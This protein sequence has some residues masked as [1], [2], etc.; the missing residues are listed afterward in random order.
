MSVPSRLIEGLILFQV[1]KFF[2]VKTIK[3]I[4]SRAHS[5]RS[6]VRRKS[7]RRAASGRDA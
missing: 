1:E 2:L 5:F 4:L 3:S 6:A 7:L